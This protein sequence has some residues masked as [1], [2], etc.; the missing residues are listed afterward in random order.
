MN[1]RFGA[2]AFRAV[3]ERGESKREVEKWEK[4]EWVRD[5]FLSLPYSLLY[6][7]M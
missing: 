4:G 3:E 5:R 1:A 6:A 2:R 7:L